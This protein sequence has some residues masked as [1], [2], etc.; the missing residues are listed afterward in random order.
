MAGTVRKLNWKGR[1]EADLCSD[2]IHAC[3]SNLEPAWGWHTLMQSVSG[4]R[5][6]VWGCILFST[7]VLFRWFIFLTLWIL[8]SPA[9]KRSLLSMNTEKNIS[10]KSGA[11][12]GGE[13]NHSAYAGEKEGSSFSSVQAQGGWKQICGRV[14]KCRQLAPTAFKPQS[15]FAV[16]RICQKFHLLPHQH[17]CLFSPL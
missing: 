3:T 14:D 1:A 5:H 4:L 16:P 12:K 9:H 2:F 17:F 13:K 11:F 8:P 10:L 6:P 7:S 15:P